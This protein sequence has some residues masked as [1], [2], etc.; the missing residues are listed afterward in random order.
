MSEN[1]KR[2]D[3]HDDTDESWEAYADKQEAKRPNDENKDA[4]S[5]KL[6]E[7]A[8]YLRKKQAVDLKLHDLGKNKHEIAAEKEIRRLENEADKKVSKAELEG[9][10]EKQIDGYTEKAV[11]KLERR[12]YIVTKEDGFADLKE[13]VKE[14]FSEV[15]IINDLLDKKVEALHE[16]LRLEEEKFKQEEEALTT[17]YLDKLYNDKIDRKEVEEI[18]SKKD[19]L[20]EEHREKTDKILEDFSKKEVTYDKFDVATEAAERW[21]IKFA[22][23]K[24]D[25]WRIEKQAKKLPKPKSRDK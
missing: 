13:I 1:L 2:P 4:N 7:L 5:E 3:Y 21:I 9:N 10:E 23:L 16:K 22:N 24:S 25:M 17:E 12:G 14:C 20:A 8:E 11:L 18:K 15:K 19:K 6:I